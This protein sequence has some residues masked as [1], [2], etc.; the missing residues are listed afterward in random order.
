M[1]QRWSLLLAPRTTGWPDEPRRPSPRPVGRSGQVRSKGQVLPEER[2]Q[3]RVAEGAQ[4]G[5]EKGEVN[6]NNYEDT[7]HRVALML[8]A[9]YWR[10]RTETMRVPGNEATIEEMI[11][12]A[13]EA[14]RSAWI[15]SAKFAVAQSE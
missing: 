9:A 5:A 7:V 4:E 2:T 12:A 10:G 15:A 13:S 3:G 8:A 14:E 1:P 6:L 11:K